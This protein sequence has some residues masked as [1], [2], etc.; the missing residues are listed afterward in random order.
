MYLGVS[1]D[2]DEL[3]HYRAIHGLPGSQGPGS[4]VLSAREFPVYELAL[5]RL[6]AWARALELPLTLFA[7]G[8][9]MAYGPAADGLRAAAREG[10][11][12]GNHTLDHRYDL[13]ELPS[14]E[15]ERQVRVGRDV[16]EQATGQRPRGF[17]APGYTVSDRLLDAV[18]ASGAEYD[19]SV[20]PCPSYWTAKLAVLAARRLARARSGAIVGDPRALA[21][22]REPYRRGARYFERG[23]GLRMLPVQVTRGA[24]LPLIGTSLALAPSLAR[25][26]LVRGVEGDRAV[27]LELHGV[28]ALDA[29]DGLGELARFQPDL[30]VPWREKLARV[31][32]VVAALRVGRRAVTHATLAHEVLT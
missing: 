4:V 30:R 23:G 2:L 20:F 25:R 28:E 19:A 8:A 11:E 6:L 24:R 26:A 22:P 18:E 13:V 32:E 7:V 16:L 10:H 21:A 27:N 3:R 31:A 14:V 17:R 29:G 12:I 9:D 5:P 1:I 15:L